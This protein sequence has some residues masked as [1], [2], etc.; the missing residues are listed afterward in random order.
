[1][2][3]SLACLVAAIW[4]LCIASDLLITLPEALSFVPHLLNTDNDL[5]Y[6]YKFWTKICHFV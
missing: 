3:R 2:L 4:Y 6:N 1:M 5:H